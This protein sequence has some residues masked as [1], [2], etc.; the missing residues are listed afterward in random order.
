M[1]TKNLTYKEFRSE[2]EKEASYLKANNKD[3]T[4]RQKTAEFSLEVLNLVK[5]FKVFLNIESAFEVV[6]KYF[7]QEE[8]FRLKDVAKMLNVVLKDLLYKANMSDELKHA[9]KLRQKRNSAV[10]LVLV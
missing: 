9:Y 2:L 1:D 3:I 7:P 8:T 4:Y 6:K 10:K 5:D